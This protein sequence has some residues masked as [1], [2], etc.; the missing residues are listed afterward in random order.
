MRGVID[1]ESGAKMRSVAEH[2]SCTNTLIVAVVFFLLLAMLFGCSE[3]VYIGDL[4]PN[5]KP[6]VHLTNGP[7]EGDTVSY[8]VH[9]YWLGYDEDG[10]VDYYEV[11]LLPG[12]PI[13]F[14][15]A[16]TTGLDKWTKIY[17]T[18]T[19]LIV[20][21]SDYDTTVT[22]N[23]ALYGLYDKTHTFFLRAV[24]NRG[25]RSEVVSRSFTA[26]T[27]APTVLITYP[28]N[29]S[30]GSSQFLANRVTFFWEGKDPIDSPWNYQGVESVRYFCKQY[31]GYTVEDMNREPERFEPWWSPWIATDAPEDS[32]LTTIVGDDEFLQIGRDYIFAVQA[33]DD[34]GAVTS[35]FS[36]HNNV[37]HF[38]VLEP[39]GPLV[40]YY[41]PIL[42]TG[43]FIGTNYRP[44][45]YDVPAGFPMNFSWSGDASMYGGVVQSYR[46]GWDV[47]DVNDPAEWDCS[48][49]PYV[50][51]APTARFYSGVHTLFIEAL[52]DYGAITIAQIEIDVITASMDRNLLWVDDFYSTNFVQIIYAMPT[53]NQHDQFWTDICLRAEGFDPDVDIFDTT[54]QSYIPNPPDVRRVM[55]YKNIIWTISSEAEVCAWNNLIVFH[56]EGDPE[57]NSNILLFYLAAGGHLWT[58]GRQDKLGGLAS[59]GPNGMAFPCNLRCEIWGPTLGCADTSGV[60]CFAYRDYCVTALDKV[61]AEFRSDIIINRS[62]ERDALST[63]YKDPSNALT[64]KYPQLPDTL[65]L[66]DAVTQQGRFF[67]PAVRGFW[68]VEMYNPSYWMAYTKAKTQDCFNPMYRMVTRYPYSQV[69][70][71]IIAFWFTK[72]ADIVPEAEGAIAAPS[73]HFGIPLWFFDHQAVETIADVIFTEWQINRY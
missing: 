35:I 60:T 25:M 48:P 70:R 62:L 29:P 16:D 26:Y 55:R 69:N 17:S 72:Y 1:E 10:K 8:Q 6:Q 14:D 45:V 22:I 59:V 66:W 39:T 71:T 50:K 61:W 34:A 49:S 51:S 19:L 44:V 23:L 37:R 30:P 11:A 63:S 38:Y 52:D 54:V 53:E 13:G 33:M 47:V 42:G 9:F 27:L 65:R 41:E 7:V 43:N 2:V 21:A 18:D 5:Q 36:K 46:Y 40:T 28:T 68:Y 32:G 24:D 3:D 58:S 67:D 12:N 15:P 56:S 57:A 20:E 73:V 4:G 64:A 31:Y